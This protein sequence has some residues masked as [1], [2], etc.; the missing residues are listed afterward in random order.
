M[1]LLG[2]VRGRGGWRRRGGA[3]SSASDGLAAS[4]DPASPGSTAPIDPIAFASPA[5]PAS[6]S[7]V[8]P[9]YSAALAPPDDVPFTPTLAVGEDAVVGEDAGAEDAWARA[10]LACIA[11]GDERAL[12]SLYARYAQPVLAFLSARCSDRGLVEEAAAD[13]WLGCW[14]SARAFRGDSRVLTWLLSIARRQ[15][16]AHTRGLCMPVESLDELDDDRAGGSSVGIG[17]GAV[18]GSAAFEDPAE[19]A[20]EAAGVEEI[21]AAV[22]TLPP[23]LLEVATLAW[24]YEL[25]YE[26][27]ARAVGIPVGTVKSRVFRARRL[28]CERLARRGGGATGAGTQ[29]FSRGATYPGE[30]HEESQGGTR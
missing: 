12:E 9:S 22:A 16:Y 28:L 10:Q 15:L 29:A 30:T 1:R 3:S 14:R 11:G 2:V 21:G 18:G 24:L 4:A 5:A 23:G 19:L 27:I 25:P 13:T 6:G 26:E 20:L 8:A 7:A 17:P